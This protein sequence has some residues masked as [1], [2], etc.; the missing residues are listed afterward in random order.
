MSEKIQNPKVEVISGCSMNDKDYLN[1]LL[2]SEK[3]I[4]NNFSIAV[5]E[6][7]N[8]KLFDD[9]FDILEDSKKLARDLYNLAFKLGWYCLEK[10]N[11]MK[12]ETK[13][14]E[15]NSMLSEIEEK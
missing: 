5:D 11:P 4:S 2:E 6:M 7:S 13:Y 12:I 1:D 14:N 8:N 10:E 15:L 9:L 3:N